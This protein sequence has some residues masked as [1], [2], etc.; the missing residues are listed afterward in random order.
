[1]RFGWRLAAALPAL[2]AAAAVH[3]ITI[4]YA[5]DR[6][7]ELR[8]CDEVLYRGARAE[9]QACFVALAASSSD[10]RVKADAARASGDVRS[11]NAHFQAALKQYPEDAAL[12]ARWG[13]LF[14]ATHQNNEAVKLFRESLEIDEDYAPAKL[15]LAKVAAG[16]FEEQAREFAN[17][18][19]EDAPDSSVEAYLLLAR[20]DLE[21]G[22]IEEGDKKLDKALA[23]AE[24][25]KLT[26]L[27]I[28]ALKASAD[29]LRDDKADSQWTAKALELNKGYGGIYATPAY[30]YVITRRYREAI[31]LL[32]RAVEIE[33]DLYQAHSDLGVNLLRENKIVEAQQH[34]QIA[35]RGDPSARRS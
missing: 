2:C 24:R 27:E 9:A 28:Y 25:E 19:I 4:E 5:L 6:S 23:I 32:Q 1:M 31:A 21:D 11:A 8:K 22:A 30:F 33:P 18:V 20:T 34:L 13:E 26:P 15:G 12:R 16:Q 3:A 14:L 35:Y 17:A 29:L 7:P 10:L